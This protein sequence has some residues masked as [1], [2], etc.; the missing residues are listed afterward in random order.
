MCAVYD[1]EKPVL[2][3]SN[4]DAALE[5]CKEKGVTL[6]CK[7]LKELLGTEVIPKVIAQIFPDSKF[8]E[9]QEC[10]DFGGKT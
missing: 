10:I 7:T 5:Q 3:I 8:I 6:N 4:D 1:E 2:F 9:I